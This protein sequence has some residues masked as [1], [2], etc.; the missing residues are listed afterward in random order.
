MPVYAD[1]YQ[2]L[3]GLDPI[4]GGSGISAGSSFVK[5]LPK[6]DG[7]VG[8][9]VYTLRAAGQTKVVG[10]TTPGA[11]A[12]TINNTFN[13]VV[14]VPG[15][16]TASQSYLCTINGTG[17]TDFV[18]AILAANIPNVTAQVESSG[19]ISITHRSGGIIT[20]TDTA[21][22]PVDTAGFKSNTLGV[23][24]TIVNTGTINLTNWTSAIYTYSATEPFTDPVTGTLWYY[25]D[26]TQVDIMV[27]DTS[28]WKGYNN[29]SLDPRGYNLT[30]TDP[31]GVIVSP[32]EPTTQSGSTNALV[33]GDLWL[34]SG[35]LENYPR[36]YRYNNQNGWDLIDNTDG[37]SQDGIIFAD[38]RWD[39]NGTVDPITG[40]L[41][42]TSVLTTSNYLDLDAPDYRLYPRGTLLFNTRRSGF[43]VKRFVQNYFNSQ[44]FTGTLP[45]ERSAWVTQQGLKEDGSPAMGSAA[46]RNIVVEALKA[47]VNANLDLREE[48]YNF[49]LLACPGYPELVSDLVLLNNDRANTGFVIGD[50]PMTLPSTINSITEYNTGLPVNDPYVGIYYPSALTYE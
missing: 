19:S 31:N 15:S 45:T 27:N 35:D 6:N 50:T 14:S 37:V 34:D 16:A 7:T 39:T 42:A 11:S 36:I 29:V 17:P 49:S 18:A 28:G 44:S 40:S 12:F 47:A 2:A 41:V 22:T 5:Y 23:D 46:Q 8:F 20:L 43:T 24:T 3:N 9:K 10:S 25:N 13:V 1:G 4:A 32:S 21:G 38:A 26:P 33:P 48:G 30:L